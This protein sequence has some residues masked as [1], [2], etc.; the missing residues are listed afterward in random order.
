ML[1]DIRKQMRPALSVIDMIPNVHRTPA[2][3]ALRRAVFEGRPATLRLTDEDRELAFH[4]A[5]VQLTSPIGARVLRILHDSGALKLK[6]PP[7]KA[8][9]AL[10][11]YIAT[12][13]AFRAEVARI[14]A[15]D[16]GRRN[17]MEAILADPASA[18]PEDLTP[19]LIDTVFSARLGH[20]ATGTLLIAGLACHRAL[21]PGDPDSRTRAE[22]SFTCW[23]TDASGQT[24]GTP[25]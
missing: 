16:T 12:E 2:L 11:A 1:W 21:L 3:A 9:P 4:D 7:A 8:L 18:R 6:K 15:A 20:G 25:A 24:H 19:E 22:P 17:R 10:D 13:A 5:H 14:I 23:W